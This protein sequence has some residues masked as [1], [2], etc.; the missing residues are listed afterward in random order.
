MREAQVNLA[1]RWFTGFSLQEKLPHHSSL[2]RIRQRWGDE[3]FK[4]IF[5]RT[6]KACIDKGLVS[7]ETVH[8]DATLIR[9]DVSWERITVQ[10]ADKV[11]QENETRDAAE[12]KCCVGRPRTR[13]RHSKKIS[14][15][16]PD[17][18]RVTSKTNFQLEPSYKQHTAV[19]DKAGVIVDIAVT[20]GEASEG[21][22]LVETVESI[23]DATGIRPRHLVAV[24]GGA[25]IFHGQL[26]KILR[27]ECADNGIN[28]ADHCSEYLDARLV[29][30]HDGASAHAAG[31]HDVD[32][33]ALQRG[34]G[35]ARAM[36]MMVVCIIDDFDGFRIR[37]INRKKRRTAEMAVDLRGFAIACFRGDTNFHALFLFWV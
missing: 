10:H 31:D 25:C 1:M 4:K 20:T 23:Q 32:R 29:E 22:R 35:V 27:I 24:V 5:Q 36:L 6:V 18:T 37:V 21:K 19:D 8:I 28:R 16:D 14:R 33:S 26:F 15:T 12:V 7:G 17:S 30:H 2:T 13:E 11:L 9:A 3:K 34:N